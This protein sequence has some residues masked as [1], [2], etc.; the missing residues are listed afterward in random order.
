M[1]EVGVVI[2]AGGRGERMG[3]KV[4]KQFLLLN[5]RPVLL[6]S[7]DVFA[8]LRSVHEIVVVVPSRHADRVRRMLRRS[9]LN[10]LCTVV[11]G[12]PERQDSVWN[13]LHGFKR[14][15]SIVLVHDAVRPLVDPRIVKAVIVGAERH[16]AAVVGVPVKDTIKVEEREGF[17]A[18]TLRRDNLWAVQT[19]QGFSYDLLHR[20]HVAAQKAGFVGTDEASLIERMGVPVRIVCGDYGN[21]KITT[22]EDLKVAAVL[23]KQASGARSGRAQ[24]SRVRAR[25]T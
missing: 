10:K 4:P 8:S 9:R 24:A 22:P 7:I 23:Q 1:P 20:A 3:G 25:L 14:Q 15:P 6:R 12:G 11:P 16:G 19:P 2:A 5:G 18:R 21:I 17:Y 13:G